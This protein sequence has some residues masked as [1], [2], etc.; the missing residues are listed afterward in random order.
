MSVR[1]VVVGPVE[2]PFATQAGTTGKRIGKSEA[3]SFWTTAVGK[4]VADK[5]GCYVFGLRAGKGFTPWYVG[6]SRKQMRQ[7]CFDFHKLVKYN[8]ILFKGHKGTPVMFFVV[9]EGN[10]KK[11][12]VTAV[13]DIE[14][15]LIQA[16]VFKNPQIANVHNT[17]NLPEWGIVGVIR[18]GKGKPNKETAIFKK[19]MS[20]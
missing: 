13:N 9:P 3:D 18:G 19:M 8:E 1:L 11:V 6:K 7:E 5:Q 17:K 12:A 16:A 14:R 10:R 2:I 20:I 15:Y 4:N